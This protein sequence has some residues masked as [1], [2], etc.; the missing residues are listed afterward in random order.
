MPEGDANEGTREKQLW[1]RAGSPQ[2]IQAGFLFTP[3][4]G[5]CAYTGP[6]ALPCMSNKGVVE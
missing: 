2:F 6:W 3:V 5:R 4:L 1:F